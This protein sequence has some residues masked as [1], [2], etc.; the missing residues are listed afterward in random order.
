GK[1]VC[2]GPGWIA[3]AGPGGKA[4]ADRIRAGRNRRRGFWR[5]RFRA[6]TRRSLL[7]GGWRLCRRSVGRRWFAT[8]PMRSRG[9]GLS[10]CRS[11]IPDAPQPQARRPVP[12]IWRAA[13]RR[14]LCLALT[15]FL[16][17]LLAAVLVRLA[18]G[19]G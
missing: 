18:P 9:T 10:A 4:E 11:D 6:Q 12:P 1:R 8:K 16:A 3:G 14:L 13:A 7:P 17:A 2:I 5:A 15:V 19:F